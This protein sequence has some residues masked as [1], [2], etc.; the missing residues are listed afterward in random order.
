MRNYK[1]E[2]A[3]KLRD[4]RW[5][6]KRLKILERDGW[7]CQIC[8]SDTDTLNVHHL[9]YASGKEP[10]EADDDHLIT[11]CESCHDHETVA[12]KEALERLKE[13]MASLQM[14]SAEINELCVLLDS[15]T[16][17]SGTVGCSSFDLSAVS[18]L[19]LQRGAIECA[20]RG[21][22]DELS[23]RVQKSES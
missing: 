8:Y 14:H 3:Q 15:I 7:T 2:Y 6:R 1:Q 5:Q 17:A 4:P 23:S 16:E 21:L 10:W 11:L 9:H 13:K 20:W 22:Q 18:W 19:I 12:R